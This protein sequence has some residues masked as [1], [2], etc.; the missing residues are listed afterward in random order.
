MPLIYPSVS[1]PVQVNVTVSGSPT[2]L[3]TLVLKLA[4]TGRVFCPGT[5]VGVGVGVEVGEAPGM[6][7]GVGLTPLEYVTP[8]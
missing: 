3:E 4:Q 7:V 8:T 5:G 6:G 1:T 2:A